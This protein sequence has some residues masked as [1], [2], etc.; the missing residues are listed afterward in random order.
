[1]VPSG[2]LIEGGGG[3]GEKFRRNLYIS[4]EQIQTLRNRFKNTDVYT[5]MLSYDNRNQTEAQKYGPFY[6]DLDHKDFE[7]VRH[8]ALQLINY[9]RNVYGIPIDMFHLYFS[10]NKGVHIIIQPEVFGFEPNVSLHELFKYVADTELSIQTTEYIVGD[11]NKTRRVLDT[12][13]YDCRRLFRLNNSINS[14]SGLYKIGI[15]YDELNNLS[16][17]DI[18][19]LASSPRE[20]EMG[21]VSLVPK[22]RKIFKGFLSRLEVMNQNQKKR[23]TGDISGRLKDII[24]VPCVDQILANQTAEGMRNETAVALASFYRQKGLSAEETLMAIGQWSEQKCD[25]PL[26]YSELKSVV[27]SMYKSSHPYGCK[28][29]KEVSIC[30]VSECPLR[31]RNK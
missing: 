31:R 26:E 5:T 21:R 20:I 7:I 17:Q 13:I 14:K 25:P 15:T 6:I 9:M 10:G 16:E 1:M 23:F 12:A 27:K 3:S 28:K 2:W 22:A 18:R 8:D 29:F 11:T 30:N 19:Q 4:E 24:T